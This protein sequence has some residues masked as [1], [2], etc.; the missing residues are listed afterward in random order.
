MKKRFLWVPWLLISALACGSIVLGCNWENKA[1]DERPPLMSSL[2]EDEVVKFNVSGEFHPHGGL[3]CC[4][5]RTVADPNIINDTGPFNPYSDDNPPSN[6]WNETL[7]SWWQSNYS[8]A[9]EDHGEGWDGRHWMS[10]DLGEAKTF[11]TF[12]LIN[13]KANTTNYEIYISDNDDL[14]IVP[15]PEKMVK[16]GTLDSGNGTKTIYL[17]SDVTARYVQFR[18]QVAANTADRTIDE[19]WVEYREVE[20]FTGI[21][22][23]SLINAYSRG[24][25]LYNAMPKDNV[26]S[27]TLKTKLDQLKV[28][29]QELL[30]M[31]LSALSLVAQAGIQVEID[32]RTDAILSILDSIDPPRLPPEVF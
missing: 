22:T 4:Y 3:A 19:I 18:C 10:V 7:G 5:A 14:R 28:Y 26:S 6:A 29:M 13:S 21:I 11:N 8:G 17:D 24:L 16:T 23:D 9:G 15:N 2:I 30:D 31:D 25:I 12:I 20:G 32:S 27:I 1:Q